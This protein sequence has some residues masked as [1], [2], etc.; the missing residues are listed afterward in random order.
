MYELPAA[1]VV[2]KPPGLQVC[3]AEQSD[4]VKSKIKRNTQR[5]THKEK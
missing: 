4:V 2:K 3:A 1:A 5:E